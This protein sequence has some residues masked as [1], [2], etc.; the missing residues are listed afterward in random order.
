PSTGGKVAIAGMPSFAA[1]SA[2][3]TASS[4]DMR[5]TPGIA[6]TG[7]RRFSPSIRKI[8]Q[9]RSSTVRRFSWT[10]R[11]DQSA[12]RM[13]RSLLD[14]VISSTVRAEERKG[15]MFMAGTPV[16]ALLT[17]GLPPGQ[18]LADQTCCPML[19]GE[20]DGREHAGY[21]RVLRTHANLCVD[22]GARLAIVS[23]CRGCLEPYPRHSLFGAPD[24]LL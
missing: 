12:L 14:P 6:S 7:S 24:R 21:E 13:R 23:S 19:H 18:L 11:R 16:S 5:R 9:I 1:C 17:W 22:T 8:G 3:F 2:S 15:G 10:R 20:S 4:T